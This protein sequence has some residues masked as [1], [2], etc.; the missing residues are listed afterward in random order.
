MSHYR[1]TG[2]AGQL[3]NLGV[4]SHG[5]PTGARPAAPAERWHL[6]WVTGYRPTRHPL[7]GQSAALVLPEQIMRVRPIGPPNPTGHGRATATDPETDT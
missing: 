6:V 1:A 3:A 5:D 2:I 7:T 4:T